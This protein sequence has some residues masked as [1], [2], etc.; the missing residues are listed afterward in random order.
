MRVEWIPREQ[1]AECDLLECHAL[2]LE[3]LDEGES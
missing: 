2:P 3:A 1:N